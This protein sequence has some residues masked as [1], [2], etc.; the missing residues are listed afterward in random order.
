MDYDSMT[1]PELDE[2]LDAQ[3]LSKDGLKQD[4]IDRLNEI[5]EQETPKAGR[6]KPE[7]QDR[8][9]V[10][11]SLAD[12]KPYSVRMW[13]G[14]IPVYVCNECGLQRDDEERMI[15]HVIN[16]YPKNKQEQVFN[17]LVKE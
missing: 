11:E 10:I 5:P 4:K 8:K 1:V 2:L 13:A 17:E 16:H 6:V 12:E 15:L 9:A 7:V 3:G 14:K